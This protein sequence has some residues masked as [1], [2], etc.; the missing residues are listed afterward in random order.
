MKSKQLKSI[1]M[2]F[3][4]FGQ[5]GE[6]ERMAMYVEMLQDIPADVLDKVCRKAILECKFLPSIAEL[7][8]SANNLVGDMTGNGTP[9][10][11]EAWQEIEK[12]MKDTF[13][14]GKP[15]FSHP[16]ITQAVESFGW[17]ELCSVLT[18]DLP[19]VRAQLRD[20]YNN[21]CADNRKKEINRHVVGGTSLLPNRVVM[22]CRK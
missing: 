20:M 6:A 12:E 9:T 19:I 8:Q 15:Q 5:S 7:V 18:R 4:A 21:I 3:T 14:Y 10:W 22:I 2:L 1:T 11:E 16:E 17:E 13:V